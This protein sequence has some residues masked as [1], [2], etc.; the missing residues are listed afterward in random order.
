VA[1]AGLTAGEFKTGLLRV[2][3]T[4]FHLS[5]EGFSLVNA[6]SLDTGSPIFR[7]NR[8]ATVQC[9]LAKGEMTLVSTGETTVRFPAAA[10]DIKMD[11]QPVKTQ[12]SGD[13]LQTLTIPAG[14]HLLTS[15][16][17]P[18]AWRRAYQNAIESLVTSLPSTAPAVKPA[19][20]EALTGTPMPLRWKVAVEGS[21]QHVLCTGPDILA[22][23]AGKKLYLLD[24]NGT[25]RW[26]HSLGG[27][28]NAL[29]GL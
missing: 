16:K 11:S 2:C 20:H 23:T 25:A 27:A 4:M 3:A 8:P 21:V 24:G 1:I 13:G 14:R 12:S 9:D 18:E 17:T 5:P 10:G 6:T 19:P 26:S 28:V 15:C 29:T 22:G 7:A